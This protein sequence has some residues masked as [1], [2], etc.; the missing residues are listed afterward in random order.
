MATDAPPIPKWPDLPKHVLQTIPT[1]RRYD[2]YVS[3]PGKTAFMEVGGHMLYRIR[4]A[5]FRSPQQLHGIYLDP[6]WHQMLW[7]GDQTVVTL[8]RSEFGVP[9]TFVWLGRFWPHHKPKFNKDFSHPVLEWLWHIT[10]RDVQAAIYHE[11]FKQLALSKVQIDTDHQYMQTVFSTTPID[12]TYSYS[13]QP[14]VTPGP[15]PSLKVEYPQFLTQ[16]VQI[17]S[18]QLSIA[19]SAGHVTMDDAEYM[20]C[21]ILEEALVDNGI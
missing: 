5:L 14:Y 6:N 11:M 16:P 7:T 2:V 1:Y 12:K 18:V 9:R 4:E 10:Q 13:Q 21:R 3:R 15:G 19:H 20:L 17:G 8:R